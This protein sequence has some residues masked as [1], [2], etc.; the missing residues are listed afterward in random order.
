MTLHMQNGRAMT[1]AR[2]IFVHYLRTGRRLVLEQ[3]F[4]PYHDPKNGQ[5]TFAPG[6]AGGAGGDGDL[7]GGRASSPSPLIPIAQNRGSARSPF[8]TGMGGNSGLPPTNPMT[9]QVVFP[10]LENQPAGAIIAMAD[11]ILDLSGPA[12]EL[13]T[14]LTAGRSKVLIH[15]IQAIDPNYRFDSLGVPQSVEGQGRQLRTLMQDRAEAF[16]RVR[17]EMEPLQVETLRHLQRHADRAYDEAVALYKAGRL[18][19]RLSREEAIG[20]YVDRQ[21]RERL[22]DLYGTLRIMTSKE[23]PVRIIGREYNRSGT[24]ATYTV[25]DARVGKIAFDVS[26]TR[27]TLGTKQVRGFF[28][29]DFNP[30]A[31]IIIRPSQIGPNSSYLI[32]RPG[33]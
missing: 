29:G 18:R 22:R 20:N 26:L 10:G 3:K 1:P 15:E 4:N 9:L 5:F 12:R 13:T 14:E 23:G 33:N 11:N 30:E 2:L 7:A 16:Y 31:V 17:H 27:K 6:G 8:R 24:D 25:P 21:T 28:D 32:K 19:V